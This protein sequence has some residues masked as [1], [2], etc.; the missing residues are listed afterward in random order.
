MEHGLGRGLFF[1]TLDLAQSLQRDGFGLRQVSTVGHAHGEFRPA[2]ASA[3]E[4]DNG[5]GEHFGIG[6]VNQP[7]IKRTQR[8][9]PQGDVLHRPAVSVHLNDLADA[10]R[11]LHQEQN[12]GDQVF[13]NILNSETE[14]KPHGA[15][16][17]EQRGDVEAHLLQRHH[18]PQ[19]NDAPAGQ[20][21]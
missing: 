20:T 16:A 14:G 17:G 21:A 13:A 3:A 4:V 7:T 8:G 15:H 12:T 1:H 18:Q 19:S 5:R 10:E 2:G 9:S 11:L 6:N